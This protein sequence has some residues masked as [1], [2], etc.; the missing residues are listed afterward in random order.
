MLYFTDSEIDQLISEDL[1]YY[2]L[3]SHSV[4]LGSKVARISYATRHET[5]ICGTE[6]VIKI[7]EK[8]RISPTLLSV[9]GEFIDTGIKFLEGEGL[10]TNIHAIWRITSNLLEF[11]SGIATRM[12]AILELAHEVNPEISIVTTR[13]SIP[14]TKKISLKAIQAGG[15]NVHR[16]GLSDTVFIFDQHIKFL[17]G[18]DNLIQKFP[19]IGKRAAGRSITVEVKNASDALK[20]C[21]ARL[22]GLQLDMIPAEELKKLIPELRRKNASLR[23]SATGNITEE[24]IKDYASTGVDII[25]TSSPY[26]G[27]P[28]SIQVNIEPVFDQ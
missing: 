18:L 23:I 14:F 15:G 26:F 11:S 10:A 22:D 25:V 20:I 21:S 6:E 5:V 8:F 3:T 12:R 17:G 9:S 1:P 7:F 24:N 13:K 16:L 2:D 27:K 28:A 4:K 19:E